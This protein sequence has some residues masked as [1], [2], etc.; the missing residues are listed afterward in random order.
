MEIFKNKIERAYNGTNDPNL[1]QRA[2]LLF[3]L[4]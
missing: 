3:F 1:S 2:P 4:Y